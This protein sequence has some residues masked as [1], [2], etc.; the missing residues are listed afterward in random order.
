MFGDAHIATED[1]FWLTDQRA[2]I[3]ERNAVPTSCMN[4]SRIE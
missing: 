4:S 1:P 2:F 3:T